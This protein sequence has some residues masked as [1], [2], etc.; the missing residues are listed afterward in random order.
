MPPRPAAAFAA[1]SVFMR[2]YLPKSAVTPVISEDFPH[3]KKVP[4]HYETQILVC[5]KE[6]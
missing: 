4:K 1:Q 5:Q 3:E 2:A 6:R